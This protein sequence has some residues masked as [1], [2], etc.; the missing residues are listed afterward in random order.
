MGQESKITLTEIQDILKEKIQRTLLHSRHIVTDTNTFVESE[1]QKRIKEIDEEEELL[2]S[3]IE[4][5]YEQILEQIEKEIDGVLQRKDLSIDKKSLEFKELRKQF[6]ELR[7]IRNKWRK[8]LLGESDRTVDDFKKEI[9]KKLNLPEETFKT[10]ES[11]SQ[12]SKSISYSE[13]V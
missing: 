3:R 4:N 7:L 8:E 6:F 9:H 11:I 10:L 5:N 1:V 2:L 12:S 13:P